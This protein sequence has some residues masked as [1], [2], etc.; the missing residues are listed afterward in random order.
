MAP[1]PS[2]LR[3][4]FRALSITR[5]EIKKSVIYTAEGDRDSS[6]KKARTTMRLT[7]HS[8]AAQNLFVGEYSSIL[9]SARGHL[10]PLSAL[11]KTFGGIVRPICLAVLRLMTSDIL[12]TPSTG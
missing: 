6:N 5:T 8:N 2:S 3:T 9:A 7:R 4:S 11:A 12:S 1:Q 10:I